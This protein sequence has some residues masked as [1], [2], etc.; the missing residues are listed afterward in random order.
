MEEE[1]IISGYNPE[2]MR[3]LLRFLAPYKWRFLIAVTA[4]VL[5]TIGELSIPIVI[6]RTV[7]N[8]LVR[9]WARMP[10]EAVDREDLDSVDLADEDIRVA[11]YIYV[12]E[13]RMNDLTERERERLEEQGIIDDERFYLFPVNSDAKA[14][15]I[16]DRS[17]LFRTEYNADQGDASDAGGYAAILRED[18]SSLP[19]EERAIVRSDDLDGLVF[20]TTVFLFVL[21]AVLL[22]SFTQVYLLALTGQGIMKDMRLALFRHITTQHLDYLNRNPV[23][24]MVTRITNDVETIN[25]LFQNVLSNLIRDLTRM[26]GVIIALFILSIQLG[27]VTALTLPPVIIAFAYFRRRA[28]DAF[29]AVRLWVSRVNTYLSERLSGMG[30]VQMFTQEKSTEERF[31]EDNEQLMKASLGEMY[32]MATFRPIVDL[33]SNVSIAVII[34]FGAAFFIQGWVSLGIVIA[35]INYIR[36]FYQ[37]VM[38]I[39]EQFTILQSAM[40][41]GERVFQILDDREEIPDTGTRELPRPLRGEVEFESVHFAYKPGTPVLRDLS[42]SIKPGETVA[43]VGYTGAGKTTIANLLTRLWDIQDGSIRLDGV[44]IRDVRLADLRA[45]VQP[46]QQDVFLFSQSIE[47]NIRLG[48]DISD[49]QVREACRIV[50]AHEFIESLPDG[51]R[52][53]LN[54]GATN[55][56]TGQRQ[57]L[58]F[59]RVLAHNPGVIIMDEATSNIDTETEQLIQKAMF[60]VMEG[61]TS[62]VIAHRLSTI[63]HSDRI[64]VLSHGQ[65]VEEGSH[66]ELIAE[67]GLYYNLYRLQYQDD[68][69]G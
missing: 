65:L 4:L 33:L 35:Y 7:D 68:I 42:F 29:R 8:Y 57:L 28:R 53:E 16:S 48:S 34:Y 66:E 69:E 62:L 6:Q 13:Q 10:V 36:L 21:V 3:R 59:A 67:R 58:S 23:G 44:D 1:K 37:P 60:A 9:N 43:I 39:S 24:K 63:R 49:E 61:R 31:E 27:S 17:E 5:A 64:L 14:A 26:I 54:E 25:E 47:D 18:L 22:L 30:V 11:G 32:V 55:I 38:S 50:Q 19:A 20:M 12:A 46:I 45:N 51:Y 41:G 40:A 56:S 52:T 15:V 2:L